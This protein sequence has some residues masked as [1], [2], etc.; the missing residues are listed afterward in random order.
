MKKFLKFFFI[1]LA[2]LLLVI[3][4]VVTI[5]LWVV[6]TPKRLTPIVRNQVPKYINCQSE[7]GEVELTF[8]STFPQF[9]L[10]ANKL[11]LINPIDG[12][13]NDTLIHLNEL[14]GVINIKSLIK[15]KELI[16]NKFSLFDGNIYAYVDS[17]GAANFDIFG[18]TEPDT[19]TTDLIFKVIDVE[20]VELKNINVSYFDESMNLK[21]DVRGLNAR[22]NALMKT[23]DIIGSI[24]TKPFGLSIEYRLDELSTIKTDIRNL[25]TKINGSMKLNAINAALTTNPFDMTLYYDSDSLKFNTDIRNLSAVASGSFVGDSISG[26]IR[27]EPCKLTLEL[28]NENY[29]QDALIGLNLTAD[30]TLS[31]KFV[32]LKEAFVSINDLQLYTSG[33]VEYDTLLQ[34]TATD[35]SYKL[36]SWPIKSI[37][38]LV[39]SSFASYVEGIE[40]DGRLSSEGTI[41]GVYSTSSMPMIDVSVLFEKGTLKY[42]GFPVPLREIN[43]DVNIRTDMKSPQSYVRVNRFN[44]QTPQSSIKTAGMLTQLFGDIRANLNTE[45]ALALHEFADFIPDS[46]NITVTGMVSGNIKSDFT[47]S[48][49]TEMQVEKMKLSGAVVFSDFAA[50]Y[51]SISLKTNLSTVDF[52]LPNQKPSTT[53]TGFVFADIRS[54][55]L[56]ASKINTFYASLSDAEFTVEA[57]DVRDTTKIPDILLL[58]KMNK[59]KAE[60]DSMN[61][62]VDQPAGNIVV[63]P[64]KNAVTKPEIKLTYN[65]NSINALYGDY[66]MLIEKLNLNVDAENDPAQTDVILQWSPQG[67]IEMENG[68]ITM[69]SIAYPIKIPVAKINFE[70]ETFAIEKW[71][72][73]LDNSDFSLSGKLDNT[74]SWFRGDSLLRGNFNFSSEFTDLFQLM[75]LT[76]GIGYNEEEA[77]EIA[78]VS[79]TFLVPKG[80]DLTLSANINKA[81]YD[82]NITVSNIKGDVRV[83]DGILVLDD[84]KFTTPATDMELTVMYQTPRINH[85]FMGL[86]L[87]MLNIEIAELLQMVPAIDTIMP[88]LRSF[89]G[90]GEFSFAGELYTDSL[91]NV[92]MSTIRAASSIRGN[93]LVLMD[94][95]TFSSIA[96]KLRFRKQTENKVDSLSAEFT[97]FRDEVDVYPFLLVMDKYK[98]VVGGRHYLDMSFDYNISLVKSPLP[99]R[100]AVGVTGTP[101]YFKY[102][103][104]RSKFP[105][106][107]RPESRRLVE[108]R[109]AELRKMIYDGLMGKNIK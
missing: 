55:S 92:K 3:L 76:N 105:D 97:I 94:G 90:T 48:Q 87:R 30:A 20:N 80:M 19:A 82:E 32:Q 62:S 4:A 54:N 86:N 57:S 44:A 93:D 85:L 34:Q 65:S 47:M 83:S 42:D 100:L 63:A 66:S 46:L 1:S 22:I 27:L 8:F 89:G 14:T 37:M 98:A 5:A 53:A 49:V 16:V 51:D 15:D 7:I 56:E 23:D 41:S 26:N 106:F 45:M 31:N 103:L 77:E 9:G 68:A 88:M 10:R 18:A 13:A 25:S 99:I 72:M 64:R 107:Y 91:Y 50:T 69:T 6:F 73:A 79:S 78:G 95:E 17:N 52:A 33:T 96:K 104:R 40:L 101:D 58:F 28:N 102:R 108:S 61:V 43:A 38:E 71:N 12:A 36:D 109:Q 60:M 35:L 67:F 59:L 75:D 74:S 39:P 29:L 81:A 21:A 70:P 2:S 11:I 84:I 24:D